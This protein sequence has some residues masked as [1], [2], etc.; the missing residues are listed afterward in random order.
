[1]SS[2]VIPKEQ[3]S[4]YQRWEMASFEDARADAT[5][6]QA[7]EISLP[8]VDEIAGIRE[9]A[10]LE[11]Y[12]AGHEEGLAAGL[13][14]GRIEA[15]EELVRLRKIATSFGHEV[16]QADEFIARDL[17]NLSLDLA[18]AMLKTALTARPELVIPIVREAIRY[19]PTL[20]PPALLYLHPDDAL[21]VKNH[22]GE[23]LAQTGWRLTEDANLERGGCRVET[24]SNQI[25]ASLP[26]R[27]QRLAA[28]LGKES[29]WLAP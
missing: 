8:T 2:V 19:L 9:Q 22:M 21:L 20:H 15:A 10:R 27:W 17:L 14:K 7:L 23:E 13:D 25:D 11:G 29:D 5:S 26:T 12:A 3:Q 6:Q 4:A 1:M 24:A 28:A 16:A 18:N